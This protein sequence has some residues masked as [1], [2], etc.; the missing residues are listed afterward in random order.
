MVLANVETAIKNRDTKIEQ[1]EAE[2]KKNKYLMEHGTARYVHKIE[3]ESEKLKEFARY[4]IRGGCWE[5]YE[6]DGCDIQDKACGLGLIHPE[7]ATGEDVD[8]EIAQE[9]GDTVYRFS[10]ILKEK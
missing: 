3:V 1:L 4:I 8:D 7:I 5:S 2:L 9:I 6:M 10:A